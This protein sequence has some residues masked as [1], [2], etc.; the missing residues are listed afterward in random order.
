[1]HAHSLPDGHLDAASWSELSGWA[2]FPN[3][4]TRR[5]I[6]E[7]VHNGELICCIA[8]NSF[9][10][11]LADVGMGDGHCGFR[12]ALPKNAFV[13]PLVRF[14][15]R[16]AST[17]L[18]LRGSPFHLVNDAPEVNGIKAQ[19]DSFVKSWADSASE[20][21]ALSLGTFFL[22]QF[23]RVA[24]RYQALNQAHVRITK[25]WT[26]V[27]QEAGGFSEAMLGLLAI[28]RANYGD[29][30]LVLPTSDTP[31]VSIIIPVHGKFQYTHQC[32]T[33][34]ALNPPT[35]AFEVILVD[36][37]SEDE[38]LL[39]PVLLGGIRILRN[40]AN[41]G[42]VGS[43]NAGAAAARGRWLLLLNNDT[44]VMPGWLDELCDTFERDSSVGIAGSKLIFPN[45]RLQE[46]GGIIWRQ[47][48]GSNWGRDGDPDDPQYCYLRDTD[49]VSGA[50]LMI[51]RVVWS[52]VGGLSSD[53]APAYYED[54]DLCFKVRATG[55]RV[56]VQPHSRI[57]HHE[58]VS[59]GTD[60]N[61]SGMKRYQRVNQ[62]RFIKRWAGVLTSHGL[63]GGDPRIEIER[64]VRR[65]ALFLDDSVPT[66]DRDAG[67]NAAFEH[68]LSLQR[69]GYEVHFAPADSMA[70]VS[71]YT[72]E[73]ERYGIRCYHTPYVRSVEEVLQHNRN[74]FD[75][76]YVHRPANAAKYVAMIR[77]LNPA[78][79]ILYNIADL[80]FLRMQREADLLDDDV[81]RRA[82]FNM[83]KQELAA[84]NA[85][86]RVIVHS[87]FESSVLQSELPNIQVSTIPWTVRTRPAPLPF[88]ERAGVAFV[89]GFNHSP[90]RDALRWLVKEIMPLV[91][92]HDPSIILSVIG[93]G[94]TNEDSAFAADRVRIVGWVPN[95]AE[96]LHSYRL[97]IAPLRFGAGLKGK[98]LSSLA[99]GL[100]C[101]GTSYAA[102]GAGLPTTLLEL[103]SDSAAGLAKLVHAM[104]TDVEA[105]T[106]AALAGL[107]YIDATCSP[108]VIDRLLKYALN[109]KA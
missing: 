81:L 59:A 50:A 94:I 37:V 13:E 15:V 63:N 107:V 105:N 91:W 100:P 48:N 49:Y 34:I 96:A 47:G 24:T 92:N 60:V 38:T 22:Q 78:A 80:H 26:Q 12:F 93:S 21:D 55:R 101:V 87:A 7:I 42:F 11:D 56:V 36:D 88:A 58:G 71:P 29:D 54:T 79:D 3:D 30:T 14:N 64:Y 16:E 67:S 6:L 62:Q 89:G 83:R 44:E 102:E 27:F 65:R 9:R 19:V 73:L 68:M 84:A 53:F 69:L 75:I 76:V 4:P 99:A 103:V 2:W 1:M 98:L 97:T 41:Q 17:G 57:L 108:D 74:R 104:H 51:E 52:E 5:V 25:H 18:D 45:G 86:D 10:T 82:A 90:N 46:V 85:V 33:S 23:D 28:M 77:I 106:E 20:H 43:V 40:D 70:R 61:G 31:D 109:G 39:A 72:D 66:P 35:R 95:I 8:A 32:L